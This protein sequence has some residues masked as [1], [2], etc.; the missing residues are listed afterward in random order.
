M[1]LTPIIDSYSS[2]WYILVSSIIKGGG[3]LLNNILNNVFPIIIHLSYMIFF[4]AILLAASIIDF[5]HRII[6]NKLIAAGFLIVIAYKILY[7]ILSCCD[8]S[9][10]HMDSSVVSDSKDMILGHFLGSAPL[11]LL[12]AIAL[13]SKK[14][15]IKGNFEGDIVN[16]GWI[17][18]GAKAALASY[19]YTPQPIID[20]AANFS[21]FKIKRKDYI[22]MVLP[23]LGLFV[24][25]WE[26]FNIFPASNN[27]SSPAASFIYFS[28][29]AVN[30]SIDIPMES[31]FIQAT[32]I[33]FLG[34]RN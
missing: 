9:Y 28:C 13:T 15:K 33:Y 26:S 2:L 4:T 29:S 25:C 12:N 6:P 18:P 30:S 5:K 17:F 14:D 24:A 8:Y 20:S 22:P 34:N 7:L 11:F 19:V 27:Y 32:L 23:F 3:C 16:P 21:A 10:S 1:S 31:S